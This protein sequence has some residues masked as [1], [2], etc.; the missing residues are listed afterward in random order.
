MD[1]QK[2]TLVISLLTLVILGVAGALIYYFFIRV[3]PLDDA[4]RTEV[5]QNLANASA[6]DT[7]TLDQ[8]HQL[9]DGLAKKADKKTTALTVEQRLQILNAQPQ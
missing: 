5:L 7:L 1:K 4:A 9:L 8:K 2:K 3:K 6:K